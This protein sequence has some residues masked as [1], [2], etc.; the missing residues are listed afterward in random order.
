[1]ARLALA[2]AVASVASSCSYDGR[3]PDCLVSCTPASGCPRGMTCGAEGYCR[4]DDTVPCA[5][6][7][8]AAMPDAPGMAGWERATPA[9]SPAPRD[10]HAMAYDGTRGRMV[11]F[12]GADAPGGTINLLGDAWEWDGTGWAYAGSPTVPPRRYLHA[13]AEHGD[14]S[15]V[16]LFGGWNVTS[17]DLDDTWEWDGTD[18]TDATPASGSPPRRRIHA[19]AYDGARA[20]V[21]LFGG[22]STVGTRLEDTW[23]WDGVAWAEVTPASGS[24]PARQ[25]HAMAYDAARERTVLF[26]GFSTE[27]LGDTWEWDGATWQDVTPAGP[28]PLPR[29]RHAMAYDAARARVVLFGGQVLSSEWNDTWEWDGT[30]WEEVTPASGSPTVRSAH[31]LAYDAASGRVM[32]FGGSDGNVVLDDTWLWHGAQ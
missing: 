16:V 25:G 22:M 12:G 4:I 31:A 20:R 13:M 19:M 3:F 28:S 8:D 7:A 10:R 17:E 15:R 5:A 14:R 23:E 30:S 6:M 27:Y 26:G 24:P 1:M 9:E 18:W 11:V 21:V 29:N 32:L 2:S